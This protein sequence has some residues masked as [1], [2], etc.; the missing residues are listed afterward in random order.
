[1]PGPGQYDVQDK[2][3]LL[4]EKDILTSVFKSSISRNYFKDGKEKA[5]RKPTT[6]D[7]IIHTL[8]EDIL[9]EKEPE[10]PAFCSSSNRFEQKPIRVEPQFRNIEERVVKPCARKQAFNSSQARDCIRQVGQGVG[11][12]SYDLFDDSKWNKRS[13]NVLYN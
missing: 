6:K 9:R 2:E 4:N 11:V 3:K 13:F 1:M 8:N 5:L 7:A 10:R 12:G